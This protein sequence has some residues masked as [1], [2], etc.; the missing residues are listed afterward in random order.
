MKN[1]LP[2]VLAVALL[3]CQK[4]AEQ[5]TVPAPV[6]TKAAGDSINILGEIVRLTQGEEGAPASMPL[7]FCTWRDCTLYKD[8]DMS[9]ADTSLPLLLPLKILNEMADYALEADTVKVELPSGRRGY[10]KPEDLATIGEW[11][12]DGN[13]Y[14]VL[15]AQPDKEDKSSAQVVI[16]QD[17]RKVSEQTIS[18]SHGPRAIQLNKVDGHALPAPFYV[19]YSFS[20]ECGT[21]E[22]GHLF[23]YDHG[24]FRPFRSILNVAEAGLFH[25]QSSQRIDKNRLILLSHSDE[26]NTEG[27]IDA[28]EQYL[29][30]TSYISERNVFEWTG[31]EYK[32]VD[33]MPEVKEIKWPAYKPKQ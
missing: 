1:F 6:Q 24:K 33:S 9:Q 5:K 21:P 23:D 4:K 27:P 2:I 19:I 13:I 17:R 26:V 12:G 28:T 14:Q 25:V 3:G 15:C 31:T 11:R 16:Y 29:Q 8:G 20:Q 30:D 10:I 18:S 7:R 32:L 22:L